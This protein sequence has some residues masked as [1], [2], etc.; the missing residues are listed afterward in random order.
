MKFKLNF[1]VDYVIINLVILPVVVVIQ[2]VLILILIIVR[3]IE[4]L[5]ISLRLRTWVSHYLRGIS[6]LTALL[7]SM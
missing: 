1:L 7:T 3:M 6:F 5:F 4:V 2:V